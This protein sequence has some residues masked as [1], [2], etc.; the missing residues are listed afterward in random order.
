MIQ[1]LTLFSTHVVVPLLFCLW[2]W[3]GEWG[4]RLT[5]WLEALGFGSYVLFITLTGSWSHVS[6]YLRYLAPLLF[7]VAMIRSYLRARSLPFRGAP[8]SDPAKERGLK[9][10]Q[11]VAGVLVGAFLTMNLLVLRGLS[12][13]E[14][15][16]VELAFPLH[17]GVYVIGQ[18]GGHVLLNQHH[19]SPSQRYALDVLALNQWGRQASG[20]QPPENDRYLIWGDSVRSPCDGEVW[21]V[22]D[23]LPDSSP[24]GLAPSHPAGNHVRIRNGD[25]DVYLAHLLRGSIVVSEGESTRAGDVV[26]RVGNSGNSTEPH[27]H[28]HAERGGDPDS[29][30]TGRGIPMKFDGAFLVRNSLYV[31]GAD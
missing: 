2:L 15:E 14:E 9:V 20:L 23:G 6:Y 26:G 25:V 10:R 31:G 12:Y 11:L 4:T 24:P 8:P 30:S 21:S 29:F 18:G 22:I 16:A 7:I 3:R 28:I 17:S 1:L 27:L 5:W 13:P 19:P